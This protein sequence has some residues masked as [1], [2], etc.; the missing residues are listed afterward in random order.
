MSEQINMTFL[1]LIK[2]RKI[3]IPQ[4]QRDYAEGRRN[5]K[6]RDIRRAFLND[7]L[8]SV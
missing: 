3:R 5:P 8:D 4:I 2:T 1:D 6:I 7:L